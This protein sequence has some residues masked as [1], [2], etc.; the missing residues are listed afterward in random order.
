MSTKFLKLN[1]LDNPMQIKMKSKKG[2]WFNILLLDDG[3]SIAEILLFDDAL[4]V[5]DILKEDD[6]I[7]LEAILGWDKF[8]KKRRLKVTLIQNLEKYRGY[9]LQ[10]LCLLLS[11]SLV[12]DFLIFII[13]YLYILSA[14]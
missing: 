9:N 11:I 8:R 5:D 1:T 13:K 12:I 14:T 7:L 4:P 2:N 6:V 10:K 3:K